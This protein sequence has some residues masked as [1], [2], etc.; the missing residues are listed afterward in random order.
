[1]DPYQKNVLNW[2]RTYK[3]VT[4]AI[5]YLK[6]DTR[7]SHQTADHMINFSN[8]NP[9]VVEDARYFRRNGASA[10]QALYELR[11]RANELM[12]QR[13]EQKAYYHR[14]FEGRGHRQVTHENA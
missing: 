7:M 10:Q 11:Q 5:R 8:R 12:I 4:A 13:T 9:E 14:N 6:E 1:M 3:R 2:R